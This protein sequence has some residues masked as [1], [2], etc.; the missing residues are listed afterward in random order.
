MN[1]TSKEVGKII[2]ND[3]LLQDSRDKVAENT[4]L[5]LEK[6]GNGKYIK[7]GTK[8]RIFGIPYDD[9]KCLSKQ[10]KQSYKYGYYDR[11]NLAISIL[12]SSG[13]YDI[14]IPENLEDFISKIAENDGR[15]SNILFDELPE[16][17]KNNSNYS[18]YYNNSFLERQNIRR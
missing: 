5:A 13:K 6:R 9:S 12:L 7:D 2:A 11:G 17:V 3:I 1:Y 16:N 15:N 14:I 10:D 18:L 4:K 8:D